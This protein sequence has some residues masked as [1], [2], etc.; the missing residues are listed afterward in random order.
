MRVLQH[1]ELAL[2]TLALAIGCGES[3]TSPGGDSGVGGGSVGGS[4]GASGVGGGSVGG[5]AGAGEDCSPLDIPVDVLAENQNE[6][7]SI[8]VD[9]AFVYWSSRISG[10][11]RRIPKDLSDVTTTVASGQTGVA[12]VAVDDEFVYWANRLASGGAVV[13]QAKTAGS[14]QVLVGD[15]AGATWIVLD[16]LR[17]YWTESTAGRVMS[18]NK[19]GS[20][21]RVIAESQNQPQH[22]AVHDQFVYWIRYVNAAAQ[23][24]QIVRMSKDGTGELVGIVGSADA[25]GISR[26]ALDAQYLYW[27]GTDADTGAIRRKSGGLPIEI[28]DPGPKG[29]GPISLDSTHAY[30]L[31]HEGTDG[32]QLV[33]YPK[34]G[35]CIRVLATDHGHTNSM[36]LDNQ[37]VYWLDSEGKRVLR[38]VLPQ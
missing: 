15:L 12:G 10:A 23:T 8:A 24:T 17:M 37:G 11:V 2:L 14:P 26:L 29:F 18:A 34:A 38:V 25:P 36:A 19:D 13:R 22:L 4:A 9:D 21:L 32:V 6:P 33:R 3:F 31:V 28:I 16:A 1:I 20:D 7:Y 27:N 30:W 5:S 35:G